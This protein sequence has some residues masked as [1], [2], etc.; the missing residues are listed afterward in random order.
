LYAPALND[1]IDL[2]SGLLRDLVKDRGVGR[3]E[4]LET[5]LL[6]TSLQKL[7]VAL[8][9]SRTSLYLLRRRGA[10]VAA[11]RRWSSILLLTLWRLTR[12]P[13]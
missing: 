3:I 5:L 11:L 12:S 7:L 6:N 13:L 9:F 1:L 2:S 8:N 10:S 4:R